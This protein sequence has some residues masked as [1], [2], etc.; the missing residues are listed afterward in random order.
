LEN[1]APIKD[2]AES[3][4]GIQVFNHPFGFKV[5][6]KETGDTLFD[7]S[8]SFDSD[9]FNH[10]IYLAKNYMQISS[11]LSTNHYSYGLVF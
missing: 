11:R 7:T 2:I 10:Y 5:I 9:N 4:L 8:H 3:N 6:R 1:D